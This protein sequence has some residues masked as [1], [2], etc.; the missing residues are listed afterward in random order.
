VKLHE[1]PYKITKTLKWDNTT[2]KLLKDVPQQLF[3]MW[4]TK[5]YEPPVAKD[6]MV[7]RNAVSEPFVTWSSLLT[8]ALFLLVTVWKRGIV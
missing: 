7:P 3:G 4:Q 6:G 1:E 2:K 8:F 5:D